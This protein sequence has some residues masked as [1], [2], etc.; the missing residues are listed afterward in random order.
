VRFCKPN[1]LSSGF[2]QFSATFRHVLRAFGL[3]WNAARWWTAAWIVLLLVQGILPVAV[4]YLTRSLVNAVA[5]TIGKGISFANFE[6]VLVYAGL[7]AAA[8]VLTEIIQVG[9]E[10]IRTA[11]SEVVQDDI[12]TLI[13]NKSVSVDLAFYDMAEF[14]DH[15][16]RARNDAS[17]R[18]LAL[19]ESTGNVLQNSVTLLAM[20]AV[21]IPY[22]M[23]VPVS[24]FVSTVPAFYVVLRSS[25]RQHQWWKDTTPERRRAQYYDLILT[26]SHFASEVRLFNLTSH[27]QSAFRSL[28]QRLRIERLRLMKEQF[29]SRFGAEILALT[30]SGLTM[31][32]ILR[33]A[34]LGFVT[35]GDIALFYQAF[36]RGQGLIRS[37]LGSL[38]QIYTNSLFLAN[39]FEFLDLRSTVAEPAG[40]AVPIPVALQRGI[41]FRNVSFTYPGNQRVLMKNFDLTIPAGKIVAIVGSNGAGKSTLLKLLCRFY[42]PIEGSIELDGIDLRQ[43]SLAELR[44]RITIMFQT[45]AYYQ[46]TARQNIELG[47]LAFNPDMQGVQAAA[48]AAGA[49]EMIRRLPQG[50][51]TLL[52]KWFLEGTELSAG[53]WQR[54]ATARAFLRKADIIILDE[55]TSMM[56]S[57]SEADWFERLRLLAVGRTVII[58]THRLTIAMRAHLI[59][60]MM[61]GSLVEFGSHQ[62]LL[63]LGGRYAESWHAQTHSESGNT[64]IVGQPVSN[65]N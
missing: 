25:L 47:S 6:P 27:F 42:D 40:E 20:A 55:P 13:Q 64:N 11:Q 5:T 4:V 12:S 65:P 54:I 48:R 50:Y 63:E 15:L 10:W 61:N 59:Y 53:E 22:G 62:E 28:R 14:H 39:L 33:Q 24:L 49:D 23:W 44:N 17:T 21:L 41:V 37:L 51:E 46:A 34:L 43:L 1:L 45:P 58:I 29:A 36:Q 2:V 7:M 3:L 18:P 19:L 30:V 26:D 60:V 16:Y 9:S 35:L 57:W 56:D 32:W 8:L 52:G 38:G 31:I